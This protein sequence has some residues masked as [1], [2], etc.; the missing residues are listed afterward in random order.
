MADS[1]TLLIVGDDPAIHDLIRVMLR[2]TDWKIENAH[3][4]EEALNRLQLSSYDIVLTDILMPSMDGLTLL[5]RI[6]QASPAAIV[7]VMTA[8]N[9]PAHVVGSMRGQAAG[10]L[11]KP[12]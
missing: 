5:S 4:G 2:D 6:H 7:V 10:Y 1:K 8:Y 3:S 12:F 11:S 9:K